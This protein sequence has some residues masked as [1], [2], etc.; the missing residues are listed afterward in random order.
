MVNFGHNSTQLEMLV[1]ENVK[2]LLHESLFHMGL[3][4]DANVSSFDRTLL[5]W[6][7]SHLQWA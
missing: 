3:M 4:H 6:Y 7:Y 5:S 1:A 2:K